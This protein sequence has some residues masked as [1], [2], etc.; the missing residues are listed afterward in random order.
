ME[1]Q[2]KLSNRRLTVDAIV[3][4]AIELLDESGVDGFSMRRLG[5]ALGV[6]PMAIYHHLPNKR[7][8]VAA[9]VERLLEPTAAVPEGGNWDVGV[10]A[11]A[12]GYWQMARR[13]PHLVRHLVT[14]P[15]IGGKAIETATTNL[16]E[17]VMAAGLSQAEA[18]PAAYLVVD[19]VHGASASGGDTSVDV[20]AAF[21][22]GVELILDG[23]RWQVE[24][25]RAA[26]R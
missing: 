25:R 2:R 7:A 10:R 23:V 18:T 20:D 13:H 5:A 3:D 12:L 21:A 4:A 24:H 19:F 6:D 8:V 1:T 15:S 26:D 9:V 14:D 17:A 16:I 22:A 11:W